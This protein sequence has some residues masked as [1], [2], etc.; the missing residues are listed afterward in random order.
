M[1]EPLGYPRFYDVVDFI[2]HNLIDDVHDDI[3]RGFHFTDDPLD[4]IR[5]NTDHELARL[6]PVCDEHWLMGPEALEAGRCWQCR[7]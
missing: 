6:C 5:E 1:T 3:N 7:T 4:W 2:R